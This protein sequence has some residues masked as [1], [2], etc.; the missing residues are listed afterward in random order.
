MFCTRNRS[1]N[2]K[3]I[4][5]G[6]WMTIFRVLWLMFLASIVTGCASFPEY[7]TPKVETI[8]IN[9]ELIRNKPS[10]YMPL[11]YMNNLSSGDEKS[12][13]ESVAPLPRLRG[14]VEKTANELEVFQ[15]FTFE[16]F[17]AENMDYVLEIEML[18]SGS[19]GKAMAA[20][21]ITG[22][23]LFLVPSAATDN[24]KLTAKLYDKNRNL[25]KTY[26]YDDSITTWFGIWFIP[27]AGYTPTKAVENL[28]ENMIKT[29]F[30]DLIKDNMLFKT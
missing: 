4:L 9:K 6:K 7:R 22:F 1:F 21:F 14:I 19:K 16:S 27:V 3:E 30:S 10:V 20:G 2:T 5:F 29:L 25:V 12:N 8:A 18:N 26:S 13:T 17:Q 15:S 28:W 24:F 23:T 11:R